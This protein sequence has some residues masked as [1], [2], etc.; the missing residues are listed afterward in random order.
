VELGCP[1]SPL[2]FAAFSSHIPLT[3]PWGGQKGPLE[4][5]QSNS[6]LKQVPYSTSHRKASRVVL[7]WGA[8]N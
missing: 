2:P 4:I 7:N 1:H 3:E 6:L 5:I 8:Q